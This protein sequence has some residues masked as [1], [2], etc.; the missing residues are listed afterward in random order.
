MPPCFY[1]FNSVSFSV[2]CL[3]F[4]LCPASEEGPQGRAAS[5][6]DFKVGK[7][8]DQYVLGKGNSMVNDLSRLF[9]LLMS[10]HGLGFKVFLTISEPG[11]R[12]FAVFQI[13]PF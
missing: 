12:K 3:Q 1:N 4:V 8:V 6:A 7:F 10:L 11:R 5:R 9:L 2:L 13:C